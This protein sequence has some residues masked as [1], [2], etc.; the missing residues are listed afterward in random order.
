MILKHG[1]MFVINTICLLY[2]EE[3]NKVE[4]RAR[5]T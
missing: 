1:L 4:T 5:E 2:G 3:L